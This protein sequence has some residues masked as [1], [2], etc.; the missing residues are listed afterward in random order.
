M[1]N[2]EVV[3]SGSSEDLHVVILLGSWCVV[4]TQVSANK[5][6]K[7]AGRVCIRSVTPVNV[8]IP[9]KDKDGAQGRKQGS[10]G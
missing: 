9:M 8:E 1:R 5:D 3:L 6:I 7:E 4:E 10:R 2:V